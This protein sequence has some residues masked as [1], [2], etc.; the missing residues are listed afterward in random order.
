[1]CDTV[2]N[3]LLCLV[4]LCLTS[5]TLASTP[6][7]IRSKSG[8]EKI[9]WDTSLKLPS[10]AR[11][12]NIGVKGAFA[13]FIKNTLIVAG[14]MNYPYL[15]MENGGTPTWYNTIYALD[16]TSS[17]WTLLPDTLPTPLA[18][19]VT[20]E[21]PEGLLCIGGCDA[22]RAYKE[23]FLLQLD[24]A[25]LRIAE[26][27][28]SLPVPLAYASGVLL[29][30]KMYVIGGK[31]GGNAED[32]RCHFY[33][34][35]LA[36]REKGWQTLTPWPGSSRS[37]AVVV[38]QSNGFDDCIYLFG[39]CKNAGFSPARWLT[40]GFMYNP[41]LNK[42]EKLPGTFPVTG[43]TAMAVGTN[44]I[45]FFGGIPEIIPQVE[46]QREFDNRIRLYHTVTHTLIEK[47]K[48]ASPVPIFTSLARRD[49]A[50]YIVS[51]EIKPGICTPVVWK[52]E[53]I[54]FEKSLGVLNTLVILLYFASLAAIGYYFSKKQKNTDDYF[55]GGG[56]LPWWA[57]GL[58][59]FG[60]GLSAITF[61]SI[62]AKAYTSDWSYLWMNVGIVLVAPLI[63]Y[64][65]IPFYRRLN[66]TTVYEYLELRFNVFIR[67]ICSLAFILFQIGR[68]G[69][70][71]YLPAIA[72]NVV[73]GID[74]FVCI[75]LMGLLSL[76]YT[77]IGGIEAVVWTDALQVVVLVGGAILV[78]VVAIGDL[79]GGLDAIVNEASVHHKFDLGDGGFDLKQ[80]TVWTV[81][82]ATF[83]TNL[84]TYGT[85]QTMVQ[86]Y[87]TTETQKQAN[88]S[89]WTNAILVIPATVLFFFVGTVLYV[90]YTHYPAALSLTITEGDAIL[91]WYI[92]SRLPEGV[93]GLL[94]S[95]IFAAA[96]STLSSSM[97][98]AATAYVTDIHRK[99]TAVPVGLNV[100]KAATFLLGALGIGFAFLMATWK[101]HSLWDQ[102]NQILGLILGSMGGLFVLGMLTKRANAFGAMVGILGSVGVQLFVV[103]RESVHLLLYTSTGFI[104]CF[105]IGYL[106]SL[107]VPNLQK[108]S[109]LGDQ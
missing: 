74:I 64:L 49:Q 93:T 60:T 55:K 22:Q 76:L 20:I 43:A 12:K 21:L 29:K 6:D 102:F 63:I 95:G 91:P 59:I 98:S 30:N 57:V 13:G 109:N 48:T 52:G 8:L 18:Q 28:P 79:P 2:K 26:D 25:R 73:T 89:V 38:A 97:N 107:M 45:L 103:S 11:Q 61:M 47:E 19:G 81:L 23:V 65:F 16:V 33:V 56:R 39:G 90:Y 31:E 101:I 4:C 80:S 78:I 37:H 70:V 58:S 7:S 87:M 42:W 27:W 1:M 68:M 35:D 67:V 5:P 50:F 40:D 10:L 92:Y 105:V 71:M 17:R 62:P 41:R 94:I 84:T 53:V 34:L 77:M 46:N 69:I 24:N 108:K 3:I 104:S 82:I 14:G 9:A 66:V 51:G 54:P 106:A 83:F 32:N 72:L 86:R 100:A 88:K 99:L 75:G 96:M 85:D 44:H 36:Q 15:P